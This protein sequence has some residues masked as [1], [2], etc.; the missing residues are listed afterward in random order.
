VASSESRVLR[1]PSLRPSLGQVVGRLAATTFVLA[2][3]LLVTSWLLGDFEIDRARDALFAGLVIG[4][5]DAL[6]WPALAFV[7]VPLSVYTLGLASLVVNALLIWVVLDELP[8]VSLDGFGAA[9]LVTLVMTTVATLLGSALALDDDSWYDQRMARRARRRR[10]TTVSDV[11]GVV[12]V[13]IDGLGEPVL[14]VALASGDVPTLRR[15]LDD[16]EHRVSPWRTEWSS[17]TGVSQCGILHGSTSEMPAFRW[18]D[19]ATGDLVV[20]NHPKSALAIEQHHSDGNGLLARNG[21]SYGN[22]YTGDAERAVLT[23]SV[24]GRRKEG[25]LGA[26]YRQYFSRPSNAVRTFNSTIVEIVRERR[27]A[28]DQIQRGVQPRVSRN[29][30]YAFLRAFTTI[31][32][33]DVCVEGVLN[34]MAEGRD[35]IYIDFLGYD[36]VSHHSGPLREDT[37]RVLRDID[38]QI[39]RFER[40]IGWAPRPY[41]I[42]VLSD[43]GQTQGATF[44]DRYGEPLAELVARL[45]G[46]AGEVDVDDDSEAGR[47]ESSAWLRTARNDDRELHQSETG[48]TVLA[49]GNLGLVYLPIGD[50]RMTLEE[51]DDLHPQLVPGLVAHP[52]IGFV[53]VQ[54]AGEGP[55]V[56]GSAGRRVI[57]TG[58]V[59][60]DDPLAPFGPEAVDMVGRAAAFST[61]GDVMVNSLYDAER[62]EV[63]AFEHQVSSHGGLGGAQTHPFVLYP[64]ELEAPAL[65]IEG[66]SALH[67]VLKGWLRDLGQPVEVGS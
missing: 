45:C 43:H 17:Q 48:P 38:R 54:T 62:D 19:K 53:L 47:T 49:S 20:S 66:P 40:A 58:E 56:L 23:M 14:R 32:S 30:T 3:A 34:D 21:S 11:P 55:V 33:R 36:E 26:G 64:A 41:R 31:I 10:S 50:R 7:L 35:S 2:V 25:R 16:G 6:V 44:E 57:D 9:L 27:A 1:P 12:F 4:L 60:G 51:I 42:V 63:A 37:L 67:R 61:A 28:R 5:V 13:Q 8:G 46:S 15:W 24:A 52:G 39:A 22:L 29:W 65:P 59:E 18:V